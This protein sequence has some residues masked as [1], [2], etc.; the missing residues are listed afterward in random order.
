MPRGDDPEAT[1]GGEVRG[2]GDGAAMG[3]TAGLLG[4]IGSSSGLDSLVLLHDVRPTS[5]ALAA[6]L[7]DLAMLVVA[8]VPFVLVRVVRWLL[9]R[10]G[11]P[12]H[13]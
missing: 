9:V 5:S 7:H 3:E 11:V 10:L 6:G 12:E 8:T 1:V 2:D 13:R 4:G